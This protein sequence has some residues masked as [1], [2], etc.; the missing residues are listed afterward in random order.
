[1]LRNPLRRFQEFAM[2]WNRSV[3]NVVGAIVGVAILGCSSDGGGGGETLV[4]TTVTITG[5]AQTGTVSTALALPIGVT[6]LDQNG[7]GLA[8]VAVTFAVTTGGGSLGAATVSSTSSG[9]ATTTLTLGPAA[10]ASNNTVSIGVPGYGG[11]S[12]VVTASAAAGAAT[13]ISKTAGDAQTGE[14]AQNVPVSP[15]VLVKDA[16]NNPVAGATVTWAVTAGGGATAAGMSLTDATGEAAMTWSLGPKV[17]AGVHSLKA[18]ISGAT[19]VTFTATGALTAGTLTLNG[20]DNQS[21]VINTQLATSPS[22]LVKTPGAGALPVSGVTVSWAVTA[23]GGNVLSAESITDLTG[24]ATNFWTVGGTVG[25]N[26]QGLTATVAGL[27]GSP[28]TFVASAT[29]PPTQI[30]SFSGDLQT[31]AAGAVLA[32]P[33]VV[34]VR[35]AVSAPVAGV[36]VTW[37]VTGGGGTLS[38]PSSITDA[39]GH[40]A[41]TLTAGTTAGA[42][43]QTVTGAVTGLAGSPVTFTASVVAGAATQM[44]VASGDAQTATVGTLLPQPIAVVVKDTYGNVKSGVTVN[45]AAVAGSGSTAVASSVTNA[46]GIASTGW[47]IGT[48]AGI[49]SQSAT[50]TSAGLTGSPLTFTASATAGAAS[51]LAIVSGDNQS[52][53]AGGALGSAL[54]ASVKDAFGNPVAGVNVNWAAATGGGSVSQATVATAANGNSSVFRTLGPTVGPQTTTAS[55]AGTTPATV[56]FNSTGT[57]VVSAYTITVRYLTAMTPARQAVFDAAAARWAGII[58]GDLTDVTVNQ[59]AGTFCGA[60]YPAIN[61]TIDDLLIFVTLDSIDGPGNILGSAGPC[62]YRVVGGVATRFSVIGAMRFDTADVALMESN[63]IFNSVIQHEM[64]HV[65]GI[66][67]LWNVSNPPPGLPP[68]LIGPVSGGGTDPQF[69]GANAIAQFNANGGAVY[70]GLP[71]PVENCC[72]AGTRDSHWREA[73]MG[74]ELMTG[75]VSFISNPLSSITIGSLADMGYT[76]SYV[77]ADPYTVNGTNLRAGGTAGEIRL[78][79]A[80]PDWT[81][82][83]VD[84][85]GRI[86]RG[87]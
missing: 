2:R 11:P 45:W 31:G 87:R 7:D 35:N 36:T 55:A 42:S 24:V 71:V 19:F 39:A 80:T 54:V 83:A 62:A 10:G 48:V 32:Q 76:V 5:N 44:A 86:T 20:G 28:V 81:I 30:A 6:I 84:A 17:G 22:V 64:G 73:V 70:L 15:K 82:K 12:L 75:F 56:T 16:Q 61:E 77:N 85:Q 59:P 78:I 57:A 1:M 37:Q 25:N 79:E 52:A 40:A 63:G 67:S 4:P 66:G 26:N 51:A 49:G 21:G 58:T 69:A 65:I 29:A 68:L 47:T 72:G 46:S 3:A 50:A 43:N 41:V 53:I 38:A 13:Q 27:T 23:G 8:G 33:F 18:S 34:L 14:V 9:V 74:K 60:T